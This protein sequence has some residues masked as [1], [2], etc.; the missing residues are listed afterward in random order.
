MYFS[1]FYI[2]TFPYNVLINELE[3][4]HFFNIVEPSCCINLGQ[5]CFQL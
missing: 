3:L 4:G 5:K 2:F 1:N